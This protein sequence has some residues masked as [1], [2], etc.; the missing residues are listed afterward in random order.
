M[1]L[2]TVLASGFCHAIAADVPADWKT[3]C[4]GS[5]N[6]SVPGEV[7]LSFFPSKPD[8][9]A[10]KSYFSPGR[11]P[12]FNSIIHGGSW[13][14]SEEVP[15]RFFQKKRAEDKQK[16]DKRLARKDGGIDNFKKYDAS[17][18]DTLSRYFD[19]ASSS[20]IIS[21]RWAANR[22]YTHELTV[23]NATDSDRQLD[24]YF[25]QF[26]E[27][28]RPRRLYEIPPEP[29]Y[30]L[31]YGFVENATTDGS[32]NMSIA[33]ILKDHPDVTI[34]LKEEGVSR[35]YS[36]GRNEDTVIHNFLSASSRGTEANTKPLLLNLR[37]VTM[38]GQQGRSAFAELTLPGKCVHA[39]ERFP[40]DQGLE[41]ICFPQRVDYTYMAYTRGDDSGDVRVVP[42]HPSL[43]LL[44]RRES[45]YGPN[46]QPTISKDELRK[47]AETIA[48][49]VTRR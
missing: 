48:A 35:R 8:S 41:T 33:M 14:I 30:C 45:E 26:A 2:L 47:M 9:S 38:G 32:R 39:S 44:V 27:Q 7:D 23:K 19:S 15:Y 37:S 36:D 3:E 16:L 46:G 22:L 17:R 1:F 20:S 21:Y 25:K 10:S 24:T 49:S 4:F 6:I 34:E 5:F 42:Y 31:P 13:K 28:F 18:E 43:L 11:R 12:H 40:P 29:G